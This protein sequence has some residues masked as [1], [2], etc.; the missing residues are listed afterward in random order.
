MSEY[1]LFERQETVPSDLAYDYTVVQIEVSV[2][3]DWV[4]FLGVSHITYSRQSEMR[5]LMGDRG[6][7]STYT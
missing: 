1:S 7:G 3:M 5:P 4:S 6:S 2:E